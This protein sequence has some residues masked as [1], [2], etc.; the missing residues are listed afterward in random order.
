MFNTFGLPI[1]YRLKEVPPVEKS[2]ESF[3]FEIVD[4]NIDGDD[5]GGDKDQTGHN[6]P[7]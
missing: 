7:K 3:G 1:H 5:L 6:Q 2:I 4:R